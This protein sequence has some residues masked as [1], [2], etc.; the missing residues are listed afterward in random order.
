[1]RVD[2]E[3]VGVARRCRREL[4]RRAAILVRDQER[5]LVRVRRPVVERQRDRARAREP[6][7]V[8]ADVAGVRVSATAA[9]PAIGLETRGRAAAANSDDRRER[10]EP[11]HGP[12]HTATRRW[13]ATTFLVVNAAV[14]QLDD[15]VAGGGDPRV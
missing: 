3:R 15:P 14:D 12:L 5:E 10:E 13:L 11:T 1:R 9:G 6:A 2:R 7:A 4:P 8:A